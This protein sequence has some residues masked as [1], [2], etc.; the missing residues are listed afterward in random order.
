M[1]NKESYHHGSLKAAVLD[2]ARE[3]IAEEGHNAVQM[4]PLAKAIG[5]T[6]TA[7]YGHFSSRSDL[8]LELAEEAH[9]NL[10]KKMQQ[11]S[12]NPDPVVALKISMRDFLDFCQ[13]SPGTFRMMYHDE[14][15]HAG[16]AEQRLT[17]LA[18]SYQLLLQMVTHAFPHLDDQQARS[19]LLASWSTLYG[20]ALIRNKKMLMPYMLPDLNEEQ[21]I[22]QIVQAAIQPCTT[23]PDM[24]G[25]YSQ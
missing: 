1:S 17:S 13:S 6:P 14:V 10:Y 3:L 12:D 7:L 25:D 19:K 22:N 24:P 20:F 8:L 5:V 4:R 18:S 11:A 15:L 23:T 2:K 9:H 21:V 16:N